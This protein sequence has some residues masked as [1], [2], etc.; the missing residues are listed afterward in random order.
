MTPITIQRRDER[1]LEIRPGRNKESWEMRVWRFI[2]I[3][4]LVIKNRHK[5]NTSYNDRH[6]IR[7]RRGKN[8]SKYLVF[9]NHRKDKKQCDVL[10]KFSYDY[11]KKTCFLLACRKVGLLKYRLDR[12]EKESRRV[13]PY[14]PACF[15][16]DCR[17][18]SENTYEHFGE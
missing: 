7:D 8:N 15:C 6:D 11:H 16:Y 2:Y 18:R 13:K 14:H 10:D 1:F 5:E 3:T 12:N 17:V 9:H 4:Y